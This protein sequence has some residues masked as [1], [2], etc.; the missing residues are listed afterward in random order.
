MSLLKQK[1]TRK[2]KMDQKI[3]KQLKFD[4]GNN[5]EEYNIEGI[6][7]SKV[8]ARELKASHLLSSYYRVS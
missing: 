7:D 3:V 4:A 1:T 2:E 8:Y 6:C 5:N